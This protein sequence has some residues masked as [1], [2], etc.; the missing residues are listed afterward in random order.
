VKIVNDSDLIYGWASLKYKPE[1]PLKKAD[2]S[3]A[4]S[5]VF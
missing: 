4:R 1:I 3:N 5:A 2:I